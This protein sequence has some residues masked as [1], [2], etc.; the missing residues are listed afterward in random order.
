[1]ETP[2]AENKPS[3][4]LPRF[5]L[6]LIIRPKAAFTQ[7]DQT[8][9]P[10][11]LWP[12]LVMLAVV[13]LAPIVTLPITQREAVEGYDSIMEQT[14]SQFTEEQRAVLE[15][16][17]EFSTN[18]VFL[19]AATGILETI[20][21]PI[22]W[23]SAA[24][25]LYLLSL[26]FGG[27]ARF[28]SIFSMTVWASAAAILSKIFLVIGTLARGATGQP[29]LSYLLKA[30]VLSEITPLTAGLAPIL[31]RITLFEIWYLIL[32]F[33]GVLVCA[34]VTRVKSLI[35]T[36]LYWILSLIP[37]VAMAS[38]SVALSQSFMG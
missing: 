35:I 25:L 33:V 6:A 32:I 18:P 7:L 8:G 27:Q 14:S 19:V 20:S 1:M 26:A 37:P 10:H 9:K 15:Q 22:L 2:N 13:W 16:Q 21:W 28:G 31:S 34:K 36:I 11:F 4:S 17:R 38:A 12:A 3:M 24:G 29:G 23:L 5:L 30:D